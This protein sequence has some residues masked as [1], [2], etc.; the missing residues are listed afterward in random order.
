M[1]IS[2]RKALDDD[3]Y[4]YT[5]CLISCLQ[6]AYRDIASDAFLDNL[7]LEREQRVDKFKRTLSN[8]DIETYCVIFDKKIIGFI[9]IH[10]RDGEIWAVYLLEEFRCKGYG[11]Q[12]LDFAI[13]KLK[14]IGHK[15]VSLWVFEKNHKARRFYERNGLSFSGTKRENNKYGKL[16]EQL[17][18][19]MDFDDK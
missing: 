2:I 3:A 1:S 8:P 11:I 7:I 10:I 18:Y 14:R 5:D 4:N 12:M 15:K 19:T 16:L 17:K 6:T 9:T 13:N